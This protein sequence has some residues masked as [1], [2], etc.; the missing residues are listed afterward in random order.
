MLDE[1]TGP[2]D[3][4]TNY[5]SWLN[6][7]ANWITEMTLSPLIFA[8]LQD[9]AVPIHKNHV[10]RLARNPRTLDLYLWLVYF[11]Y[12]IR[13]GQTAQ[14]TLD[15]AR[16]IPARAQRLRHW[17]TQ[18]KRRLHA[19]GGVFPDLH[20]ELLE[21]DSILLHQCPSPIPSRRP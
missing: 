8:S 21:N 12:T 3:E 20:V 17:R 2:F 15:Q 11:I 14:T 18:R 19:I 1:F 9:H 4:T 10:Q 16:R 7:R 13:P 5:C 6:G